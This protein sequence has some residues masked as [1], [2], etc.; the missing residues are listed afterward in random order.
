V[1]NDFD[2]RALIGR[3]FASFLDEIAGPKGW[4]F[5]FTEDGPVIVQQL[6]I[7]TGPLSEAEEAAWS[8][9]KE[10]GERAAMVVGAVR[11]GRLRLDSLDGPVPLRV[12]YSRRWTMRR[13]GAVEFIE[14]HK[15]EPG[16]RSRYYAPVFA[17]GGIDEKQRARQGQAERAGPVKR[18]A[19]PAVTVPTPQQNK[20]ERTSSPRGP[21]PKVG[22]RV[23]A[24]MMQHLVD[25]VITEVELD[26]MTEEAMAAEYRASRDT[27]RKARAKVLA[28]RG[29]ARAER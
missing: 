1:A 17:A 8:G 10:I 4:G 9:Q 28:C 7:A 3:T 5:G 15:P 27:C 22:P 2:P 24:A 19:A 29:Y 11:T 6:I 21:R 20:S 23:R 16:E 12:F 13:E 18:P 25:K 14:I 26:A